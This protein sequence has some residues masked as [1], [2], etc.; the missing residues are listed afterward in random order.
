MGQLKIDASRITEARS[1]SGDEIRKEKVIA[2]GRPAAVNPMKI[3][4]E[5][6]EQKGVIVPSRAASIFAQRPVRPPRMR[7]VRSGGK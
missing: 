2:S 4:I 7:R 3:G 6:Q 5:E 1:T